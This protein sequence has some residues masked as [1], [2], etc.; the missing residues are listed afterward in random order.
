MNTRFAEWLFRNKKYGIISRNELL[1]ARSPKV[2]YLV[3]FI[4]GFL[5]ILICVAPILWI[6]LSSLKDIQELFAVPPT[7]I[8][9][10]FHPEKIV[11]VWN[12]MEFF[13]YYRNSMI[14]VSGSILCAIVFNGLLAYAL[15]ILKPRGSK[16]VFYLV[17][18]SLMIPNIISLVPIFKN[19]VTL[20]LTNSFIPLCLG[21]G[22]QAFYVI[23]YKSFFD[24]IPVSL[25]EAAR[26][27]GCSNMGIFFKIVFPLSQPIN[28]VIA[29]FAFNGAWSDFILSFLVLKKEELMTVMVKL[30]NVSQVWGFPKDL[31]LMAMFFAVV[32]PILILILF[33]KFIIQG[34]SY[35]GLKG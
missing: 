9:R 30:Y 25:I 33:Q 18:W 11:E 31:Q 14:M 16:F 6:L 22:A 24:A 2:L 28:V 15:S 35:S 8:P 7:I 13:T 3:L 29:I 17:L 4:I 27:D 12:K 20:N 19:I 26:M 32:P 21:F 23:L 1:A 5:T 10:S 34:V